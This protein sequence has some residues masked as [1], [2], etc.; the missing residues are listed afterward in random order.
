MKNSIRKTPRSQALIRLSAPATLILIAL[1]AVTRRVGA[2]ESC[3]AVHGTI[4]SVSITQNC[5]SPI[6]IC[7]VGTI[8]GAGLLN[9]NT[10]FVAA[11]AAPSAGMP[12]T[13]PSINLSYSGQLTIVTANGHTDDA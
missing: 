5:T 3:A 11:D 1:G 4:T 13:E 12:N 8:T 6:G 10:T 9:G 7:T 2:D